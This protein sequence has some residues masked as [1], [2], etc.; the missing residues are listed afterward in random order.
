MFKRSKISEMQR[1]RAAGFTLANA[2]RLARNK[3]GS[4]AVLVAS[5]AVALILM[6]GIIAV[7]FD[8]TRSVESAK[9]NAQAV[10]PSAQI[11]AP[12]E[13]PAPPS[14]SS[15]EQLAS[16]TLRNLQQT[17]FTQSFA[18]PDPEAVPEQTTRTEGGIS[19]R[20]E[21]LTTAAS[22]PVP[23]DEA[24]LGTATDCVTAL[25]E[26]VRNLHL[27]FA[28]ASA[29]LPEQTPAALSDIAQSLQSCGTARLMIKGHSD[30]TGPEIA[31]IQ[32]S[33][34]RADTMMSRLIELG[35]PADQLEAFGFGT[36]VPLTSETPAAAPENRRVDFRVLR[37]EGTQG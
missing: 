34:Q 19:A 9:Q 13:T 23:A 10:P 18:T 22:L 12:A 16:V 11:A 32:I 27:P 14:D 2:D 26:T 28:M 25:G 7:G 8:L 6:G 37:R 15:A 4:G 33:W 29:T 20:L 1:L 30:S 5:A 3:R 21:I 36:R 24:S 17:Q 31:N 35:A